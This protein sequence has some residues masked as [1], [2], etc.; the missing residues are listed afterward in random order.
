MLGVLLSKIRKNYES[1]GLAQVARSAY[2]RIARF[3]FTSSNAYWFRLD[4]RKEI[5]ALSREKQISFHCDDQDET[6][7]YIKQ[8]GYYYPEEIR[9]GR[10]EGHLFS[11]LK[12]NGNIIGYNT[13]GYG[14]VYIQD[15]KKT[16]KFPK[17][18]AFAYHIFIDPEYRN[19]QLGAFLFTEVSKVLKSRGFVSVW[20]HIPPWNKASIAM[21]EKLRFEKHGVI[22]YYSIAGISWTSTDPVSFIAEVEETPKQDNHR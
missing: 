19:R 21:H 17:S 20:A 1:G 12:Y 2:R 18:I 14:E 10:A 6:T 8:H 13:T 4:L 5:K 15:F 16:Y 7:E 3:L 22:R 9:I 11:N